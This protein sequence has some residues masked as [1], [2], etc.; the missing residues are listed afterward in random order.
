MNKGGKVRFIIICL[1]NVLSVLEYTIVTWDCNLG[2][3]EFG[4]PIPMFVQ[5]E[6]LRSLLNSSKIESA[7]L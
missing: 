2:I 1:A 3:G 7:L 5:N 6:T 4:Y